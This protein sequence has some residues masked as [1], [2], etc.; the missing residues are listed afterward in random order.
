MMEDIYTH[1]R[2]PPVPKGQAVT[3]ET[4]RLSGRVLIAEDNKGIAFFY[5]AV[6]EDLGYEVVGLAATVAEAETLAA[7]VEADLALL[8]IQLG[9]GHSYGAARAAVE[10]GMAVVFTT[11]YDDPPDM[12]SDLRGLRCLTKPLSTD[13][14]KAAVQRSISAS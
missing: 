7:S 3:S 10:R 9:D 12:P 1:R 11:G 8:D 5:G 13:D 2:I 6:L 4:T 14:L